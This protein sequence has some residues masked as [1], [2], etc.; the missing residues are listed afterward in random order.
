MLEAQLEG[1]VDSWA[2]LWNLSVFMNDGL[3]LYPGKSLVENK[4]FDGSGIHCRG[5]A[6][7]QAVETDFTPK[8]LPSVG[9][10]PALCE[11]VFD[12][13]RA[14]RSPRERLRALAARFFA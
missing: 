10:D 11:R 9:M 1:K 13:F 4:G 14:R 7:D 3:V 8:R 12:Y 6:P 5:E 2:I